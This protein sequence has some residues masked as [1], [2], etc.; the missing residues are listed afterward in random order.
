MVFSLYGCEYDRL[1]YAPLET[2]YCTLYHDM[3]SLQYGCEDDCLE[4]AYVKTACC[5]Y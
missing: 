4:N 3:V 5:I 2:S 1:T